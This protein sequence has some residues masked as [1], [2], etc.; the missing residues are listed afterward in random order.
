MSASGKSSNR[1]YEQARGYRGS[2]S[3]IYAAAGD[4]QYRNE[5]NSKH[6]RKMYHNV[7]R[8]DECSK[9]GQR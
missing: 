7:W 4:R 1:R 8:C 2:G 5:Q 3:G 6:K 9:G